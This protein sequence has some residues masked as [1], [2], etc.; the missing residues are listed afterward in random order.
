MSAEEAQ[1]RQ[2]WK[3]LRSD[4]PIRTQEQDRLA[5]AHLVDVL[6]RHIL[7]TDAPESAI[8][9]LNAPWGAGKSSFLNLLE[10]KLAPSASGDRATKENEPIVIRFNPWNYASVDQLIEMFFTELA[11]GIGKAS[12]KDLATKIGEGLQTLGS[13]AGIFHSGMGNAI[14]DTSAILTKRKSLPELKGELDQLLRDLKQRVVVFID[15]ID[16]LERDTMRLLFRV[17]RLN[18]NFANVTWVL[19]FDRLV[20]EKHLD[21]SNGIRGRDYL[22]KITQVSFDIPEPEAMTLH[23]ILFEEMDAVLESMKTRTLDNHRWGNCFQS[24]FKEHFRTIRQ[25]KRYANGLQLTL[26]PV[27]EEVDLV[28]FMTIELLRVFHPEVYMGVVAGKNMLAPIRMGNRNKVPVDQLRQWVEAL[29][30][31]ASPGFQEH[32]LSL[33]KELFPELARVY[34]NTHYSESHDEQ[35]RRDCR[36]C[37]PTVF[38]T[39]FLLATPDGEVSEVEMRAFVDG[40]GNIEQTTALLTSAHNSDRARRLLE[41]LEDFTAELPTEVLAPLLHVLFDKGDSL[42]F[43]PRGFL[44]VTA[45]MQVHRI[46]YLCLM[47]LTTEQERLDILLPFVK[48]GASLYTVIQEVSMDEPDDKASEY[49]ATFTSRAHWETLRDAAG[50]RIKSANNDGTLWHLPSPSL[51][52]VLGKWIEWSDK[53]TVRAAVAAHVQSDEALLGFVK[54]FISKLPSHTDG[55][56]VLRIHTVLNKKNLEHF[57]DLDATLSRLRLLP[58]ANGLVKLWE[59]TSEFP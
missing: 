46:I 42:R 56:K 8:I 29:S 35:W 17:I 40:I 27:S 59:K 58:Q 45:K 12:P 19:A 39:F 28:D 33:L 36:V 4:E 20:V 26:A 48:A 2:E 16:R 25:I 47:K 50:E 6:S 57:L 44:D 1:K 43:E 21:E 9:A 5:R 34:R 31:K 14:R 23:K 51:Q 32:V 37:A 3:A 53:A 41:R 54:K 11:R 38:D 52:F 18:A 22:E 55:D 13:I 7:H 10:Q 15:D 24:G 30:A 49:K